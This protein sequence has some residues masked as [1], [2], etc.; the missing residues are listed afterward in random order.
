MGNTY[1]VVYATSELLVGADCPW[2]SVSSNP[3]ARHL[4]NVYVLLNSEYSSG[5]DYEHVV[6]FVVC[7][8]PARRTDFVCMW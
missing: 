3:I 1:R 6:G 7:V 5:S 4:L 2:L 8:D